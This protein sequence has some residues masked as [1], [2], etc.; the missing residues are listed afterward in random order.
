MTNSKLVII[1]SDVWIGCNCMILPDVTN[2]NNV[3]I[4]AGAVVTKD[5]PDNCVAAGVPAKVIKQLENDIED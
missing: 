4:A 1:G 3:I 2:G 5:I